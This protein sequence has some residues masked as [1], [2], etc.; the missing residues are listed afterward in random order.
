ME[1]GSDSHRLQ[2]TE[3]EHQDRR[4]GADRAALPGAARS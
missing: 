2:A 1:I 3:A 4:S